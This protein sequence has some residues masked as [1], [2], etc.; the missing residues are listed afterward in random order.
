M[1]MKLAVLLASALLTGVTFAATIQVPAQ[2][3]PWL[4]GMTNG[5]SARR[6]DAAPEQSPVSVTVTPIQAGATYTFSVSGLANHGSTLPFSAADGEDLISHY[7]GAENGIADITA[8]FVS[9][10]GVFLGSN[11]PDQNPAPRPL[12]F[13][14][15]AD[16]DYLALAPELKQPF[17]IGDGLTTSGAVQQVIAPAGAT[18]L[19]LGIMDQYQWSDNEGA[20]TVQVTRAASAPPPHLVLHPSPHPTAAD[21]VASPARFAAAAATPLDN[22]SSPSALQLHAFTAIELVWPSEPNRLYQVQ[23]TPSLNQPQWANLGPLVS[24]SGAEVS[25]FDSTR[26]HPQGFYWV[27]IMP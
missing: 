11:Q 19:F 26:M 7:L 17:F 5:T 13:R 9:L 20:F 12:D 21:A 22:P 18:R 14:D 25:M 10:I 8:P 16:R 15:P 3:N 27:Q 1:K 4:A 24:G 6:S 23:W 2:A